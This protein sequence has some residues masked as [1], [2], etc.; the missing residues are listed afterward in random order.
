M[1]RSVKFGG[2]SRTRICLRQSLDGDEANLGWHFFEGFPS[3]DN[4]P[5]STAKFLQQQQSFS[6]PLTRHFANNN[7]P[8]VLRPESGRRHFGR[9]K[10]SPK[11]VSAFWQAQFVGLWRSRLLSLRTR[12][13]TP[14]WS[15]A[16]NFDTPNNGAPNKKFYLACVVKRLKRN[17]FNGASVLIKI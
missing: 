6:T 9:S 2:I 17:I 5:S 4:F 12:L 15:W 10:W 13:T 7:G 16:G 3:F 1:N 8:F 14:N 11:S